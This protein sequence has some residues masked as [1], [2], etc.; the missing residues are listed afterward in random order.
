L[1][2]DGEPAAEGAYTRLTLRDSQHSY[3]YTAA[4]TET[5]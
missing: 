1:I 5:K 3:E 2:Y 4:P